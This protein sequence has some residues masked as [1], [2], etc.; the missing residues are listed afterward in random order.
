MTVRELLAL[1]EERI[2]P[3]LGGDAAVA[4]DVE[5]TLAQGYVS[6]DA[7]PA[8]RSLLERAIGRAVTSG[9]VA[10]EAGARAGLAYVAYVQNHNDEATASARSALRLW[11]RHRRALHTGAGGVDAGVRR[12]HAV[13]HRPHEPGAAR[14]LR[15]VSRHRG[16]V[17]RRGRSG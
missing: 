8:A 16:R 4:G 12:Q 7:F 3:V 5:V 14:V 1:A 10:R 6:Q 11:E 17:A 15:G 9:D 2:A 13:L